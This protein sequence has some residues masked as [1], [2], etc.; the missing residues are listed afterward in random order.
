MYIYD[1]LYGPTRSVLPNRRNSGFADINGLSA[2]PTLHPRCKSLLVKVPGAYEQLEEAVIKWIATCVQSR[3]KVRGVP[4]HRERKLVASN[5]SLLDIWNKVLRFRVGQE[6][7]IKAE[8]GWRKGGVESVRFTTTASPP[9]KP[10][11]PPPKSTPPPVTRS[12]SQW[13]ELADQKFINYTRQ[14]PGRLTD[15][16]AKELNRRITA[17]YA[18]MYLSRPSV[19]KWAGMAALA[20]AEVGRGMQQ[21]W[22]LGF[23]DWGMSA[24][25]TMLVWVGGLVKTGESVGPLLGKKLFWALSGGNR[26]VWWDIFWQHL[27]YQEQGISALMAAHKAGE[28]PQA[29]LQAWQRIDAGQ[30]KGDMAQI[31]QG[32][33]ELLRY[34]QEFVLQ[35]Q[36]YD[37]SRDIWP[38]ISDDVPSPIPGHGVKFTSYVPGGDIGDFKHRWKWIEESM[39][40]A[41]KSLETNEAAKVGSLLLALT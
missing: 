18:K 40:P 6:V 13:R 8:Y 29:N 41:W 25:G 7:T 28:L 23:G 32:N 33:S 12:V 35:A 27:A 38:V 19:F 4:V 37:R 5:P 21:A 36:V 26:F 15:V 30:Q 39:L 11:P 31:W 10:T 22:Q 17:S 3:T 14:V 1:R 20:S 34:E 16:D 9:P 2:V 24:G